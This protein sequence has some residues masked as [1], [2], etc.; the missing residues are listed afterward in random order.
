MLILVSN[1][2]ES[3]RGRAEPKRNVVKNQ[4][5]GSYHRERE[6]ERESERE[7]ASK[8]EYGIVG[9]CHSLS[10]WQGI[11]ESSLERV[12]LCG[13]GEGGGGG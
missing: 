2:R 12:R 4:N 5:G 8:A 3:L 10:Y 11:Q 13:D 6:G 1:K 9:A 7:T